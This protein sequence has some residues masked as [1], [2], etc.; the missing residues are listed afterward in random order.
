[1]NT[2]TINLELFFENKYGKLY[3]N[4]DYHIFEVETS[5][6]EDFVTCLFEETEKLHQ[7]IVSNQASEKICE[8]FTKCFEAMQ[9]MK[10]CDSIVKRQ[11]PWNVIIVSIDEIAKEKGI[12]PSGK[13]MLTLQLMH[14]FFQQDETE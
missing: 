2:K 11:R 7:I 6:P 9:F 4:K 10:S 14:E 1:M 8:R 3:V 5:S 12:D 13:A